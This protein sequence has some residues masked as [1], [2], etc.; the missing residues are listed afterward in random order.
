MQILENDTDCEES[1]QDEI[2]TVD[3]GLKGVYNEDQP[4]TDGDISP[5]PEIEYID[6]ICEDSS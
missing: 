4:E 1:E 6:E 2:E 5:N 3:E